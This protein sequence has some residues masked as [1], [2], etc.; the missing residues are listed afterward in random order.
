MHVYVCLDCGAWGVT[1]LTS[2]LNGSLFRGA[3][4]GLGFDQLSPRVG[5]WGAA[6]IQPT[7]ETS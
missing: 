5:S 6:G 2:Y 3:G 4:R 1:R 7:G